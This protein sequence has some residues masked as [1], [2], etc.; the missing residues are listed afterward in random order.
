MLSVLSVVKAFDHREHGGADKG[1]VLSFPQTSDHLGARFQKSFNLS[2]EGIR[3][4]AFDVNRANH[5]PPLAI[6]HRN[7]DFGPRDTQCRQIA[8][9][10]GHVSNIDNLPLCNRGTGQ[11]FGKTESRIFG[12]TRPTP[13]NVRHN[14][15]RVVHL[16]EANPTIVG[17][18][19]Y[20]V[21]SLLE[22]GYTIPSP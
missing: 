8:G 19:P 2:A 22:R 5:A 16:I 14:S 18:A 10:R 3:L 11:P 13:D 1:P 4:F 9:I 6:K 12:R 21:G 20:Q 17:A 7:N 15:C